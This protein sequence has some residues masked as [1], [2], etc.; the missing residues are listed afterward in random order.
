[1]IEEMSWG[2]LIVW[3]LY[4]YCPPHAWVTCNMGLTCAMSISSTCVRTARTWGCFQ[5][6]CCSKGS[7]SAHFFSEMHLQQVWFPLKKWK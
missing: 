2:K 3:P 1:M 4:L 5:D 6:P 7:C